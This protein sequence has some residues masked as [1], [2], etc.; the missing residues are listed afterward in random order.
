MSLD[1][2]IM[3]FQSVFYGFYSSKYSLARLSFA[4]FPTTSAN[5]SI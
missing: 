3:C 2:F 1:I 5:F 4:Y